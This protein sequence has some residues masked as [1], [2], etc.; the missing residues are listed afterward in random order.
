MKV[1][2]KI[3]L[4]IIFLLAI[5]AGNTFVGLDQL[6]K[7]NRELNSVVRRD[8]LLTDSMN[9]VAE[10]QLEKAVLME[11]VLRI[12]EEMAYDDVVPARRVHLIDQTH[13]LRESLDRLSRSSDQHIASAKSTVREMPLSSQSGTAPV[14]AVRI[15]Q[16][17][18]N[19]E[20][21]HNA[22]DELLGMILT[23]VAEGEFELSFDHLQKIE[24]GSARL[25][26]ELR[27]FTREVQDLSRKSLETAQ[28]EEHLARTL[29]W[30]SFAISLIISLILALAIIRSIHIPLRQLSLAAQKV[31]EGNF[32]VRLKQFSKDE[33][34]DVSRAFNLMTQ[35][36]MEFT[37]QLKQKKEQ[38]SE[39]LRMTEQQRADLQ[40]VNQELDNFVRTISHDIRTPL[41]G[42]TGYGDY[43]KKHYYDDMDEKG[44]KCVDGV[45]KSS[46]RMTQLIN[47]LLTLTQIGRVKNPYEKVNLKITL[48]RV[49]ERLEDQIE[50]HD[51]DLRIPDDM[52]TILCDRVKIETIFYNLISNAIKFSSK[53]GRRPMV[54]VCWQERAD[55]YEF[56]VKDNGI[57]IPDEKSDEVFEMF[58]RLHTSS[59]YEGTGAGLSI[60]QTAVLAHGGRIWVESPEAGPGTIFVFTIPER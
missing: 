41:V 46:R 28:R 43:L 56:S 35:R 58:K 27:E 26:R 32:F 7:I 21:R 14:M 55:A 15:G 44:K 34:G 24:I 12:A 22:Y 19:I 30:L 3:S 54:E 17:L 57:G 8:M 4:F 29:L 36:L 49:R 5:L 39:S 53:T 52:P 20:Q 60:V 40:Q 18:T 13:L 38:L 25:T 47:D 11:R 10:Y 2:N 42:M 51:V 45:V 33:F 37:G 9:R 23:A 1:S 48:S 31:G 59:D 6:N 50:Q 16:I